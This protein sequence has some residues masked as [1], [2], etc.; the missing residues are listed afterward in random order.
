MMKRPMSMLRADLER[1]SKSELIDLLVGSE[2]LAKV[3]KPV[4][5]Q[6]AIDLCEYR[7]GKI[8]FQLFYF[9]KRYS[10]NASQVG[11]KR[12]NATVSDDEANTV[13]DVLFKV[14]ADLR[15]VD[16]GD[17]AKWDFSRSGRTDTGVSATGQ[18]VALKVRTSVSK[19]SVQPIIFPD[20]CRMLNRRL[21][22]DIRIL[23]WQPVAD[24]FNARFDCLWREY[25]YYFADRCLDLQSMMNACVDLCGEHDFRNLCV[26]DTSKPA[27]YSTVRQV[28][29][30]D[31]N[32]APRLPDFCFLRIR[33]TGFLYHQIRCI[34]AA[35]L[36]IGHGRQPQDYI[37]TLL[38]V[39][40]T[41]RPNLPLADPHPLVF[42]GAHYPEEKLAAWAEPSLEFMHSLVN[43]KAISYLVVRQSILPALEHQGD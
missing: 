20:Y 7:V 32:R 22:E 5:S 30:A 4:S 14:F 29:C 16:A 28:L 17:R 41:A 10:G 3:S 31:I 1:L 6:K 15:L 19:R 40:R 13:E 38:D 33:A 39:D 42:V 36:E 37:R 24:D 27:G 8:A 18:V 12:D 25:H 35:L 2:S 23:N 21:P 9:G 43:H 26:P 11:F 34:M